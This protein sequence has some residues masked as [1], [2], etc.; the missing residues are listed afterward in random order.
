MTKPIAV[1]Y[2][3]SDE[4]F[5][6]HTRVGDLVAAFNGY[7]PDIQ[8][9]SGFSDYLWFI[10]VNGELYVPELKVFHEKDFTEIQYE[11]LRQ[12]IED[13][14]KIIPQQEPPKQ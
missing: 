6:P 2:L 5:G 3:P 10:F 12:M 14:V 7:H 8:M 9:P 11:E 13:G 4:Y 1:L